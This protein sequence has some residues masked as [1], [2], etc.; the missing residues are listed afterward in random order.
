MGT[1][2]SCKCRIVDGDLEPCW[3][4]GEEAEERPS[5]VAILA[6]VNFTTHTTRRVG[7]MFPKR[8][9]RKPM[10]FNFCPFCGE[11]LHPDRSGYLPG[12]EPESIREV[13]DAQADR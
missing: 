11:A 4:L 9:Q 10:M 5:Q 7:A 13:V 12:T 6:V 2:I 1:K 8:G 3:A